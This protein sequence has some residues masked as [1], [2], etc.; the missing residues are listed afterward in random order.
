MS[1]AFVFP[2]QGSQVVG[3]GRDVYDQSPAARAV[4]DQADSILGFA[5]TRLCFDG[6]E[7]ELTATANAQPA[8]LTKSLA[9]LAALAESGHQSVAQCASFV[10]GHS[11]G[12][13][14]AL[15]AAGALDL[16]TA[17]R[18]V[19]RRGELMSNGY[20]GTMAAII[21]M[22]EDA[23]EDVCAE[24]SAADEPVVIANYNAPGQLVISGA[25]AA[26]GR[27]LP[28]AKARGAKRAM[29][30]KVSAAFHSPLMREAAQRLSAVVREAEICRA[31][32]PVIS[33]VTTAPIH[34]AEAIRHELVEQ[35][36]A[37]VRWIASVERMVAAG[38]DTFVEVGPG[39]VLTGLIKRIA[40]KARLFNVND[41]SSVA[42]VGDVLQK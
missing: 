39:S 10:A 24:A 35:V 26:I 40:P 34:K 11:L 7:E 9:L 8:I 3:M 42:A 31:T 18:L 16:P 14:S 2:G 20:N 4:F 6:P 27:A 29:P 32:P 37:P 5:L 28:L 30:L 41:T 22:D 23:L 1:I 12:E 38:V 36:T 21:G 15:A 17:L 33:N 19:R 25:V 13:Y